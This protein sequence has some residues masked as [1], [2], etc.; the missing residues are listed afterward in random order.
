MGDNLHMDA[1]ETL[2]TDMRACQICKGLPLGPRPLF[3]MDRAVKILIAGQAPGRITHAKGIPFDDPSGDRLRKWLGVDR[4]V[5]YDDP[6]IGILP[7]GFCFPGSSTSGDL[8]PREECAP[9]WRE[10]ALA[11]MPALELVLI[12]GRYAIDWHMPDAKGQSI[13]ALAS[14]WQ[15]FWPN[16]LVMPHPS[17]RNNRWLKVNPWFEVDVIPALQSRVAGML[18]S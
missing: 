1:F 5:F 9:T 10:Q 6:R 12:I 18:S 8:P 16:Q 11:Q 17:P 15:A 2:V 14:N 13:T 7:M 4:D 3:K